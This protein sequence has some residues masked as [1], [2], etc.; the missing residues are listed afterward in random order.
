MDITEMQ[1][2][3]DW[4]KQVMDICLSVKSEENLSA[5]EPQ[6]TEIRRQVETLAAKFPVPGIN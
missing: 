6:L 1:Q 2:I 4:M 3:A 5:A